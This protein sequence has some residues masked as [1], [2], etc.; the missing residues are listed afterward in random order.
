MGISDIISYILP[1]NNFVFE[2]KSLD[3]P[4]R[5]GNP[6]VPFERDEQLL[7]VSTKIVWITL[8]HSYSLLDMSGS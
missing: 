4:S 6:E 2:G 3:E 1:M 5:G 8:I 7:K